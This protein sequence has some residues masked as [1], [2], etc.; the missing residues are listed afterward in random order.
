[1]LRDAGKIAT[2]VTWKSYDF[3]MMTEDFEGDGKIFVDRINFSF[4]IAVE[5]LKT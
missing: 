4:V 3:F 5:K 2:E 1:M